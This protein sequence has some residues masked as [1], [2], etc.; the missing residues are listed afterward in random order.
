MTDLTIGEV[1]PLEV[2][3]LNQE[4]YSKLKE[5]IKILESI[6]LSNETNKSMI[7]PN[8]KVM[9]RL[10]SDLIL[11]N[12]SLYQALNIILEE[13]DIEIIK[14]VAQTAMS[15]QKVTVG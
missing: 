10:E 1:Y 4:V 14:N 2:K 12:K 5:K 7:A 6:K 8:M 11:T 13:S 15:I 9:S 3:D